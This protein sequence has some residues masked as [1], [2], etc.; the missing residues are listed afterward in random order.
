MPLKLNNTIHNFNL[1]AQSFSRYP[2][3]VTAIAKCFFFF[4]NHPETCENINSWKWKNLINNDIH[5]IIFSIQSCSISDN[6]WHTDAIYVT[7]G[8][9][10]LKTKIRDSKQKRY[11]GI[12]KESYKL[13]IS[14]CLHNVHWWNAILGPS[15]LAIY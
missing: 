12:L 3:Y 14:E 7:D 10:R 1:L 8:N 4:L 13:S 2:F 15:I 9:L 5:F 11:S 6:I